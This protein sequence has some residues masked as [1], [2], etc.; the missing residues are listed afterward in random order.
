MAKKDRNRIHIVKKGNVT[1][2]DTDIDLTNVIPAAKVWHLKRI[3]FGSTALDDGLSDW[4]EID[5]GIGGTRETIIQA[6]LRGN[7]FTFDINRVFQG[8]GT[9]L[10]RI[11]RQNN[12][13]ANKKMFVMIEGFK[14]EGDVG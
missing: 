10:F 13:A 12:S 14:R 9:N 4:F 11:K 2:G 7:T 6:M 1:A 5:W 8:D 3:T